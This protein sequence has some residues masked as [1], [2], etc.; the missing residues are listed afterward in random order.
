MLEAKT[1]DAN[2]S[3]AVRPKLVKSGDAKPPRPLSEVIVNGLVTIT[4]ELAHR[5]ILECG[6]ERQRGVRPLH[7]SALAM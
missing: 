6:Y 2:T 4:P 1:L 7:V 5:I 3:V